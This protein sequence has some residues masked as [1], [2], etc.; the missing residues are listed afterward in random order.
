[1]CN[2]KIGVQLLF[3]FFIQIANQSRNIYLKDCS[4]HHICPRLNI[5]KCVSL[6]L[7]SQFCSIGLFAC[8]WDKKPHSLNYI[9]FSEGKKKFPY[10]FLQDGFSYSWPFVFPSK[11]W[12]QYVNF[13][14]SPVENSIGIA[15]QRSI[16]GWRVY[17]PWTQH[18]PPFFFYCSFFN[19]SQ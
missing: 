19:F 6:F 13:H 3:L 12:N 8:A 4:E 7:G 18:R 2:T 11:F 10:C 5:H 9:D 1:M 14:K 16:W 17:N 15:L